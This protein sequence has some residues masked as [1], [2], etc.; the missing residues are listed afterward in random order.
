MIKMDEETILKSLDSFD[1][2]EKIRR[3]IEDGG[4]KNPIDHPADSGL[5][6]FGN[7]NLKSL[8]LNKSKFQVKYL[9]FSRNKI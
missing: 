5:L 3:F 4:L 1:E 6:T 2:P 9:L 8:H 7:T